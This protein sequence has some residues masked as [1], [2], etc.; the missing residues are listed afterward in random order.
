MMGA[1]EFAEEMGGVAAF[2]LAECLHQ[3]AV[4]DL[5]DEGGFAGAADS[6]D[7]DEEAEGNVDVDAAEVVDAGAGEFEVLA[8]G[9]AAVLGDGDGEA[10]GEVFAGDGV[11]VF[12][13][14]GYGAFSEE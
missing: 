14:F 7:A 1:G 6:G 11:W 12:C 10:A 8:A 5:M 4:E 2:G 3:G 9:F 13:H